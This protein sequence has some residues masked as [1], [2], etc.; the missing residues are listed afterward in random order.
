M[1][2]E[3]GVVKDAVFYNKLQSDCQA[4]KHSGDQKDGLKEG[5]DE[6]LS[7][8]ATKV[9]SQIQYLAVL[10]NSFNGQGFKTVETSQLT[11]L[12]DNKI[13]LQVDLGAMMAKSGDNGILGCI[14]FRQ[15]PFWSVVKVG[16]L[17]PG[18]NFEECN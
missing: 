1:I 17:G 7:V 11:I 15:I 6:L 10:V 5:Y 4:I 12:H 13:G 2:D 9:D 16:A 18:V 14:C 3:M 8:D